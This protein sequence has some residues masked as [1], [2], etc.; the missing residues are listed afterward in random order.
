MPPGSTNW[1]TNC[2]QLRQHNAAL[3]AQVEEARQ[4]EDRFLQREAAAAQEV[5]D[6][7]RQ[8]EAQ[9]ILLEGGLR[10]S[11]VTSSLPRDEARYVPRDES[12]IRT[13]IVHHTAM[14][15]ETTLEAL[16]HA[17]RAEWPGILFDFVID[18]RG[19]VFQTQPLDR[20]PD[21]DADHL[22]RAINIAFAGDYSAGGAP[23][24]EQLA[25]GGRLLNWLLQRYT[26]PGVGRGAR[27]ERSAA[28]DIVSPGAEWQTGATWKEQLLTAVRRASGGGVVDPAHRRRTASA[29]RRTGARVGAGHE[30][31]FPGRRAA[32]RSGR[33]SAAA[34][35]RGGDARGAARTFLY[36]AQAA[37]Q[38]R[39]RPTA[40]PPQP[41]LRA[42]PAQPDH[43]H[44]HPPHSRAAASPLRRVLP[45]C[46]SPRTRRGAKTPG[47][48]SATI[49]WCRKTA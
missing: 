32:R 30:R 38:V 17:H 14:P 18:G 48:A 28:G 25:A 42:S 33:R 49:S 43:P 15:A 20:A 44:R 4:R 6:L 8:V 41:A 31:A 36:R 3:L 7:R 13:L 26:L 11:V 34:A 47:R 21:A 22:L 16:A 1:T 23:R 45:N 39:D 24:P 27:P 10:L 35:R 5:L 46:T 29:R 37:D 9:P 12:Q 2:A 40:A 19:A